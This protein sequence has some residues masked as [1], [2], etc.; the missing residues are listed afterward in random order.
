[1]GLIQA[2]NQDPGEDI[3]AA[4]S[5]NNLSVLCLK[6][7]NYLEA[8]KASK[9]AGLLMEPLIFSTNQPRDP[10]H[11]SSFDE[12]L[13]VLLI[14]YFNMAVSCEKVGDLPYAQRVLDYGYKIAKKKLGDD[15]FFTLKFQ[16]RITQI[17][18]SIVSMT[19]SQG[20]SRMTV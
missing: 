15:N 14:A 20:I 2:S 16:R 11:N 1:M 17:S 12:Q 4:I 19:P 5:F 10:D 13:Q 7:G 18:Q 9:K 3:A 8:L 6:Q